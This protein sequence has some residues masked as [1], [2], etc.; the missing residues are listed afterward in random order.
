[1]NTSGGA[2]L[3]RWISRHRT[4]KQYE[5][6]SK[7]YR[8]LPVAIEPAAAKPLMPN[9]VR[10]V[11]DILAFTEMACR[12]TPARRETSAACCREVRI[13]RVR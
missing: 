2:K 5:P 8:N 7:G 13:E 10:T 9:T 4:W 1:V 12:T 6:V 11:A 3:P